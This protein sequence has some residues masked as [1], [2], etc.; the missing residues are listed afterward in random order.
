MKFEKNEQIYIKYRNYIIELGKTQYVTPFMARKGLS[1]DAC[2]II[3]IHKFLESWS[4]INFVYSKP[5]RKQIES[6]MQS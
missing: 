5:S 4:L 2:S 3:R 6:T 1:G